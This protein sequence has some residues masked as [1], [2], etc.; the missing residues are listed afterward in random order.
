M[1]TK[2]SNGS[3]PSDWV[4]KCSKCG[5]WRSREHTIIDQKT[6]TRYCVFDGAVIHPICE[7]CNRTGLVGKYRGLKSCL[8]CGGTGMLPK[9]ATYLKKV[10]Q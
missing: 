1:T 2:K 9:R 7:Y 8:N 4:G 6:Q 3:K 5:T 10:I